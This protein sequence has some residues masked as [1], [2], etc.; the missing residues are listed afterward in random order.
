VKVRTI[1]NYMY[2]CD[3]DYI[4]FSN[5]VNPSNKQEKKCLYPYRSFTFI[6]TNLI[7]NGK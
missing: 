6:K 7:Q 2:V 1:I 4:V 3:N 5:R